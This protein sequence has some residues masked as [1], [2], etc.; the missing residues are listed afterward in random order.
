MKE[1]V[2]L[3][4]FGN[5][6]FCLFVS[7]IFRFTQQIKTLTKRKKNNKQTSKQN[8]NKKK[9]KYEI[10]LKTSSRYDLRIWVIGT[11]AWPWHVL[12]IRKSQNPFGLYLS[13]LFF[14]S[15]VAF[16]GSCCFIQ[17]LYGFIQ[18]RFNR[19]VLSFIMTRVQLC[20]RCVLFRVAMNSLRIYWRNS[21]K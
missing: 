8:N 20:D 13:R 15:H 11:R 21:W 16:V 4:Q 3:T 10:Q 17:K 14:R 1:T 19:T 2:F 6:G 5:V 9:Q 7:S 12:A 18:V